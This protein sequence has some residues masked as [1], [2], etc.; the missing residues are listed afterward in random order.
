MDTTHENESNIQPEEE[1]KSDTELPALASGIES[2]SDEEIQATLK[3]MKKGKKFKKKVLADDSD[4]DSMEDQSYQNEESGNA[5]KDRISGNESDEEDIGR[6][7]M[8]DDKSDNEGNSFTKVHKKRARV[9]EDDSDDQDHIEKEEIETSKNIAKRSVKKDKKSRYSDSTGKSRRKEKEEIGKRSGR[10][11]AMK[12]LLKS[13]KKKSLKT[14]K[15]EDSAT[16][17]DSEEEASKTKSKKKGKLKTKYQNADVP[18]KVDD[19]KS[20]LDSDKE[21]IQNSRDKTDNIRRTKKIVNG[22]KEKSDIENTD[23]NQNLEKEESEL[24]SCG[25][26]IEDDI[27]QTN[28]K[29]SYGTRQKSAAKRAVDSED[30]IDKAQQLKTNKILENTDLFEA[31]SGDSGDDNLKQNSDIEEKDL[32]SGNRKNE[33]KKKKVVSYSYLQCCVS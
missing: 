1:A 25:S 16:S 29:K 20:E 24:S 30:E 22:D 23:E 7:S 10:G 9:L 3:R 12:Q 28:F 11:N 32:S 6:D 8:V 27:E 19:S 33:G 14:F 18:L 13:R 5:G 17:S 4:D 2:E 15:E 31:E 21:L 26:S